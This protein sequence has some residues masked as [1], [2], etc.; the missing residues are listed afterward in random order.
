[1]SQQH[2]HSICITVQIFKAISL[3][4]VEAHPV[5]ERI[6]SDYADYKRITRI[7]ADYSGPFVL[8]DAIES[9]RSALAESQWLRLLAMPR[10]ELP[11]SG[12]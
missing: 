9:D 10:F 1:M 5:I 8:Q 7:T 6:I 11:L 4:T 3:T 12:H 2:V